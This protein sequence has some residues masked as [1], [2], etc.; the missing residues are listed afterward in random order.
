[1]KVEQREFKADIAEYKEML[2]YVMAAARKAGLPKQKEY[3]LELGF[4]ESVINII[5]YA[6]EKPP[7]LLWVSSWCEKDKVYFKLKDNGKP[8]D[9]FSNAP[10]MLMANVLEEQKIGGL[11]IIFIKRFFDE[12]YYRYDDEEKLN[13]LTL[14]MS[15]KNKE[16]TE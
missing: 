16:I 10:E 13:V 11:G 6:Y 4:E 2:A 15:L 9:P 1:M 3:Y 12:F 7:G 14:G 8:F 5:N